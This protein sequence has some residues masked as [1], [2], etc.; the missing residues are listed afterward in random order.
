MSNFPT[1]LFGILKN[2]SGLLEQVRYLLVEYIMFL[3]LHPSTGEAYFLRILLNIVKGVTSFEDIRTIDGMLYKSFKEACF[4][5]GLLDDD[6]E[7]I[8]GIEEAST[9]GSGYMCRKLF[10]MLLTSDSL[11][12][13]E[14]VW[15]QTWRFLSDDIYHKRGKSLHVTGIILLIV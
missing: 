14:V 4:A 5:L 7:Y 8:K 13:P 2:E 15:E 9:W 6:K 11:S 1:N 12:R 3:H 10:V